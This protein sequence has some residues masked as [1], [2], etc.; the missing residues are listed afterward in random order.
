MFCPSL[1]S[2][3]QGNKVLN[4]KRARP[5]TQAAQ[6]SKSL[7][8]LPNPSPPPPYTAHSYSH[9]D[10]TP[11]KWSP[12]AH[13]E[14]QR[15]WMYAWA[16]EQTKCRTRTN[17]PIGCA[18][19]RSRISLASGD[20]SNTLSA[21]RSPHVGSVLRRTNAAAQQ[22]K[23]W[24]ARTQQQQQQQHI[25]LVSLKIPQKCYS[26]LRN[27]LKFPTISFHSFAVSCVC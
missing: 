25:V 23:W 19:E 16:E 4:S 5:S 8:T 11:P 21:W 3:F 9:N 1:V 12:N 2:S 18:R 27:T 10:W 22:F 7:P 6:C 17:E 24:R 13:N 14:S 20:F 26:H 15:M